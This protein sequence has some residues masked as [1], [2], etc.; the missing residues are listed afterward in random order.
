M[1]W[2]GPRLARRVRR[3]AR[4]LRPGEQRRPVHRGRPTTFGLHGK[5]ANT[6]AHFVAVHVGDG[7]DGAI[8]VEGHVDESK[9]FSTQVRMATTV[10]T[11]PGANWLTVRDEFRNLGD[12]PQ[13]M[14]ILYHWNFGPPFLEEG[15]RFVGAGQGGRPPQ[16]AGG[17]GARLVRRLRR[18]RAGVRR[19]GLPLR[20]AR[21]AGAGLGGPDPRARWRCSATATAGRPSCS[22]STGRSSP[23]S[24]S[25]RTPGASRAGT[26]PAW[27]RA[28]TTRTRSRS[29]RPAGAS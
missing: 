23:P 2:G 19:A 27:S 5:I 25:G 4:P 9:L 12:L 20:P 8:S 15:S 3:A 17:R 13:E 29:R 18:A 14:Q 11:L 1:N 24:P 7:P 10:T 6:P 28:R 21:R 16:R 26:S 22:G